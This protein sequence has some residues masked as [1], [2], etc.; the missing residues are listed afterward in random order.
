MKDVCVVFIHGFMGNSALFAPFAEAVAACGAEVRLLTLPGHGGT[1]REFLR[2][3]RREWQ[4]YVDAELAALQAQQKTLL[5]VGHSMGG[6][7]AVNVAA[8]RPDRIV[9]IF[10]LAFPL[11]LRMTWVGIR[12]RTASACRERPGE[13]PRIVAA[14]ELRGVSGVTLWNAPAL[15]PNSLGLLRLMGRTRKN[16]PRLVPTLAVANSTGDEL[17]SFSRSLALVRRSLP[18]TQVLQLHES[19]HF[20][21]CQNEEKAL[22]KHLLH[23]L[24]SAQS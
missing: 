20:W 2:V 24:Q 8:K 3:G 1:L 13:D 7:L 12:I 9:G 21:F 6:L 22:E 16:L 18:G 5:V 11:Y 17:V 14:R 23:M 15:I 19:S 4:A 10:A